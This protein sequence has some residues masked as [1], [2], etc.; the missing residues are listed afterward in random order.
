MRIDRPDIWPFY[1]R[2]ME[3]MVIVDRI[4]VAFSEKPE[5]ELKQTYWCLAGNGWEWGNGGMG[6]WDDY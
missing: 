6:E 3:S 1:L 4:C 5:S 2:S